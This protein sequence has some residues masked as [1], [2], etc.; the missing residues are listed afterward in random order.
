MTRKFLFRFPGPWPL[1]AAP[2]YSAG[3]G[4]W[5]I[6]LGAAQG[7]PERRHQG[8]ARP[9]GQVESLECA[10]YRQARLSTRL[11]QVPVPKHASQRSRTQMTSPGRAVPPG[12]VGR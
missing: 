11:T 5:T 9:L 12:K 1:F 3:D 10:P 7:L 2:A 4:V 6:N 8:I